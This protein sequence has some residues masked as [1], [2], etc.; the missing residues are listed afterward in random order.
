MY[1]TLSPMMSRT[2]VCWIQKRKQKIYRRIFV[3]RRCPKKGQNN[4]GQGQIR[5]L[6][7]DR[8]SLK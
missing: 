5:R 6:E 2:K 1:D 3:A 7:C 8:E 4:N